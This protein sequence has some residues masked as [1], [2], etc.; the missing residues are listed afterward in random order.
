MSA[1]VPLL[2]S[3]PIRGFGF[4]RPNPR[5]EIRAEHDA[6]LA[7]VLGESRVIFGFGALGLLSAD[8]LFFG[9]F[10]DLL[11]RQAVVAP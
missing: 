7:H 9:E 8:S 4:P 10:L 5:R 6:A 2:I 11:G 1:N 3:P